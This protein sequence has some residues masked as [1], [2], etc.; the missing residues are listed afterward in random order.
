MSDMTVM[1]IV[2]REVQ[3]ALMTRVERRGWH[4]TRCD[5]RWRK[6]RVR[7]SV[8]RLLCWIMLIRNIVPNARST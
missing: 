7:W 4:V 3:E 6:V 2:R 8:V 5:V 1:R